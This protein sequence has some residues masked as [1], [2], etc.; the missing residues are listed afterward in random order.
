M[1]IGL[2]GDEYD[3]CVGLLKQRIEDLGHKAIII[4]LKYLPRVTRATLDGEG[5][6]CDGYNLFE[7]G[8]FYLREMEVRAPFFHVTYTREL[9]IMLRERYLSFEADEIENVFFAHNLLEILAAKNLIINPPQVYSH[10]RLMP[11]HLSFFAQRGF[12]IPPFTVGAVEDLR[13]KGF[14][15]ELPLNLDEE[16]VFDVLS[17]PKGKEKGMR[18]WRK[19]IAGTIYK[20]MFLGDKLLNDALAVLKGT[21]KPHKIKR[22]ELP[23][24]VGETALKAAKIMEA[25]FAEVELL[26]SA[27]EG[28]VWLLQVDPSPDF[29]KLEK[30]YGLPISE[31]LARYLVDVAC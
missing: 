8:S 14:E 2:F 1:V 26:Y 27:K 31:P 30:V 29:Y 16:R 13:V 6:I 18:I 11:F 24:G 19:K 23:K 17:F 3:K 7:M 28:I 15:E 25:K 10:R 4:N 20:V 12:S 5:I 9:W 21:V 22:K